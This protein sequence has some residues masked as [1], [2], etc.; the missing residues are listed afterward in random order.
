MTISAPVSLTRT[1]IMVRLDPEQDQYLNALVES[2]GISKNTAMQW[3]IDAAREGL[4]LQD[5]LKSQLP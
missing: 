4:S 5:Y 2:L 3:C 1:P